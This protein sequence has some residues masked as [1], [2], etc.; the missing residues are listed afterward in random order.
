[1]D[2]F[3]TGSNTRCQMKRN[4]LRKSDRSE[5]SK[6]QQKNL[7]G[8]GKKAKAKVML[9]TEHGTICSISKKSLL[10]YQKKVKKSDGE[11]SMRVFVDADACPVVGIVGK[12][13][14]KR[15]SEDDER[16]RESFEKMIQVLQNG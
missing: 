7:F 16:F 10:E 15:T 14:R 11:N 9:V 12:G 6:I 13:P 1:M 2:V 3:V 5:K 8:I 4:A